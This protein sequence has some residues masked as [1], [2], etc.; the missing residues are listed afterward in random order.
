MK[1]IL[2]ILCVAAMFCM[3]ACEGE[4]HTKITSK[5][6]TPA[7]TTTKKQGGL[8]IEDEYNAD[9]DDENAIDFNDIFKD[10]S[11]TDTPA[12]T[13]PVVTTKPDAD[14]SDKPDSSK[15]TTTVKKD[16]KVTTTTS[17]KETNKT[18]TTTTKPSTITTTTT[19]KPVEST[20]T[21]SGLDVEDTAPNDNLD[22]G[23]LVPIN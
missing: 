6:T 20:N 5:S 16:D 19:K 2:M 21:G 14:E 4:K 8:V 1:K 12:A 23:P 15:T 18:T 11:Y 10:V 13:Q 9:E 3:T 7:E 22:W 17:K